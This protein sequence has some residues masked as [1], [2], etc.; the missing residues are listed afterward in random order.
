MKIEGNKFAEIL[1]VELDKYKMEVGILEDVPAKLPVKGRF[2]SYAG[3]T[4]AVSGKNSDVMLT[5]LARD[6]DKKYHWLERPW[7]NPKNQAVQEVVN[8]IAKSMNM[9]NSNKQRVLNGVQAVVRNPILG[10]YYGRNTAKTARIKGFNKLLMST[11]TFF[12]N[13]RAR[14]V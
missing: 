10:D 5:E 9:N 11:G 1:Q 4:L 12:Q 2:K 7:R 13:I 3:Q 14:Y 8:D 6:L